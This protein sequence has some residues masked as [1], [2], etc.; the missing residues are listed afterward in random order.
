MMEGFKTMSSAAQMMTADIRAAKDL[1]FNTQEYLWVKGQILA[2]STA[3]MSEKIGNAMSQQM[4]A[5]IAQMKKS[6]DEAKDDATKKAYK[7]MLDGYEKS[8]QESAAQKEKEDPAVSY[9]RQLVAKYDSA[10]NALTA[11]AAKWE[12]KPGE[13]QKSMEQMQK[14]LDKAAQK[15]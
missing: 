11:E 13:A 15:P 3:A 2:A 7:D 6:Y 14:D 10:I 4:D 9:N 12:D 1:G 8:K 5:S